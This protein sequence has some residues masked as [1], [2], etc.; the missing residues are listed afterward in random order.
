MIDVKENNKN[1]VSILLADNNEEFRESFAEV[2][3]SKDY[4]ITQATNPQQAKELL[5]TGLFQLAIL[6]LRLIDDTDKQDK[7]GLEI[8]KRVMRSVPKLIMT[9]YPTV[10]DA[11]EAL[12]PD[13]HDL[14]PAVDYCAKQDETKEIIA[15]IDNILARYVDSEQPQSINLKQLRHMIN[16]SFN[17]GELRTLFFDLDV[18]YDSVNGENKLIK[19]QN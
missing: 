19:S 3:E 4:D 1:K 15:A 17:E 18:P 12:R 14:P 16:D 11:V 9:T 10:Q 5:E 13:F 8:A 2:L 6:D 7:S